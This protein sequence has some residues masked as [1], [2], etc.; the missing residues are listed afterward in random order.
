[1]KPDYHSSN[2][3]QSSSQLSRDQLEL[4]I[5]RY[6]ACGLTEGQEAVLKRELASTPHQSDIID[7]A[8]ATMSYYRVGQQVAGRHQQWASRH[9]LLAVAASVTVLLGVGIAVWQLSE[10]RANECV[11]YVDG[12]KVTD[13]QVVMA[14]LSNELTAIGNAQMAIE[15]NMMSQ[16]HRIGTVLDENETDADN[17]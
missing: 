13:D 16:L 8:R 7:E 4:L 14:M 17:Q 3:Q 9:T 10:D 5:E 2:Q 1:M 15:N 6:F 12:Q 11:A